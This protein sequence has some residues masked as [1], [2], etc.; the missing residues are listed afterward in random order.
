MPRRGENIYKRK[1]GRWEGRYIKGKVDK[2]TSYGYIYG[3]TYSEVKKKLQIAKAAVIIHPKTSKSEDIDVETLI[4]QWQAENMHGLKSSTI[5]KYENL[6]SNYII[7]TI[8][9]IPVST[10]DYQT[11][12]HFC[13]ELLS[14]GGISQ[15]GLSPKTVSDVVTLFKRIIKYGIRKKYCIDSSV[16]DITVK[17]KQKNIRVLSKQ[18]EHCLLSALDPYNNGKDIGILICLFSGIRI[19]EL[20]ALTW[21]DV[22]LSNN[23]ISITKTMQ[24]L[25]NIDSPCK[26]TQICIDVPKSECSIRDIPI[27]EI[28]LPYIKKRQESGCYVL[29]SKRNSFIEPRT[30]QNYFKKILKTCNVTDAN[31]HSLRHTFATRCVE[32][33]FDIKTLS[34]ILGH[35]NVSITLNRYVHPSMDLK[36]ENI[37]K[38][39]DL[40][41]VTEAVTGV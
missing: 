20:C 37:Q 21:D 6:L 11:M 35:S 28:L 30:M 1:D 14:N 34:E 4:N 5:V 12:T 31:F 17:I 27:A 36:R 18:E 13:N 7:P 10:L 38:L 29:T 41:S 3:K 16:L 15:N 2:K 8:G 25:R 40:F 39:S 26:K 23:T 32:V 19:G 9:E 22:S 33:G 24:R